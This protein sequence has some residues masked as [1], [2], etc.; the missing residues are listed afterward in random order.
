MTNLNSKLDALP[1]AD[2]ENAE[3]G[4]ELDAEIAADVA[5]SPAELEAIDPNLLNAVMLQTERLGGRQRRISAAVGIPYP[6]EQVW[7][8][9]T[10]YDHL[11]DFIPNLDRSSQIASP[12]PGT[13]RIEQVGTECFLSLKF[14]ARVVLDMVETFPTRIDF[15]MVEGDFK[16]FSGSWQ[17][18]P[19]TVE[20]RSGTNLRYV[21]TIQPTRLMPIGLIERH[22][23]KNLIINLAA[24]RQR[25]SEQFT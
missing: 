20:G 22:L 9:L 17:L 2:Q 10:D 16:A 1:I 8:V 18:E 3:S 13:V 12:D 21:V 25:V 5:F 4:V 11:A 14:C 6:I 7:Q 19:G 24:V 15:C 23:H